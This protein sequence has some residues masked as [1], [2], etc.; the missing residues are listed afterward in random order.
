MEDRTAIDQSNTR[1]AAGP[2]VAEIDASTTTA[3][4]RALELRRRRNRDSMRRARS[5]QRSEQE[6]LETT[7]EQ[8]ERR[9][10]QLLRSR[11]SGSATSALAAYSGLLR[12]TERLRADNEE[13]S[14]LAR[15]HAH[16]QERLERL[17]AQERAAQQAERVAVEAREDSA[18]LQ[19][20][21]AW[22]TPAATQA[23]VAFARARLLEVAD[24]TDALVST[25][26][27]L[28]GWQGKRAI[29]SN[30]AHYTMRKS[31][32]LENAQWLA[33]RTWDCTVNHDAA[34]MKQVLAWA[35]GTRVLH[36]LSPDAVVIARDMHVPNLQDPEHPTRLRFI[37]LVFRTELP[38]NG[39]FLVGTETLNVHGTSVAECLEQ[40]VSHRTG[41][42]SL[43]MYGFHFARIPDARGGGCHVTLAGRSGD[44]SLMY[45][46]KV[47][48]EVLPS[49]LRWE[50]TF[51]APILRVA[52]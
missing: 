39:G 2:L 49:I 21:L 23:L 42:H 13:L 5:R 28:L 8:L 50:N 33:T 32:P 35:S 3:Q 7:I 27:S 47:L 41:M 29:R 52:G 19:P 34:E 38:D 44:G 40:A 11:E 1:K 22:M 4:Q 48:F 18:L 15:N 26:Q 12:E 17:V 46:R 45:A 43:T 25:T 14:G 6:R 10:E 36:R 24:L 30:W 20:L 37:L 51:V 9:L 31:F 16:F